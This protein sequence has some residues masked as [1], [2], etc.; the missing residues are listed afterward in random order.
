MTSDVVLFLNQADANYAVSHLS[1]DPN[2]CRVVSNG[3][4]AHFM[5]LPFQRNPGPRARIAVIGGGS[6]RKGT[7]Y[8]VSALRRLLK[9]RLAVEVT[10]IG[11]GRTEEEVRSAFPAE[12]RHRVRSIISFHN[13]ELPSLLRGHQIFVLASLSEGQSLAL[14]EAMA[15]GL[16]PVVTDISGSTAIVRDRYN[17]R[18][19]PVRDSVAL[20]RAVEELVD[21][22]PGLSKARW[23][24]YATAQGYSWKRCAEQNL[25]IYEQFLY[26]RTDVAPESETCIPDDGRQQVAPYLLDTGHTAPRSR[27]SR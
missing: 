3:I 13:T 5:G 26:K 9:R 22:Q 25:A 27:R 15:C 14:L 19:V 8:L 23:R 7:P 24:A 12:I 20:E 17:G 1:V 18:V 6:Y 11:S 16:A 4:A 21:D 2:K 10:F